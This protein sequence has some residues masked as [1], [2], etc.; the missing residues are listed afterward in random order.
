[1]EGCR[2]KQKTPLARSCIRA[3]GHRI[4]KKY[5][6]CL[7][8]QTALKIANLSKLDFDTFDDRFISMVEQILNNRPRKKLGFLSPNEFFTLFLLN[9]KVVFAA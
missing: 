9:K 8:L 7:W 5:G 2:D 4:I 1:M 3:N 6:S